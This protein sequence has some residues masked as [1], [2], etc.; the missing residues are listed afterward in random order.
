MLLVVSASLLLAVEA[1]PLA[2]PN[3]NLGLSDAAPASFPC[4]AEVTGT[5]IYLRSGPGMNFYRCGKLSIPEKLT[6]VEQKDGWSKVTPPAGSFSWISKEYV[7][8]DSEHPETGLI[9]A[10]DTRVWAGSEYVEPMHSTSLQVKLSKGAKV[11]LLGEEKGDYYK[12]APPAGASLDQH[13]VHSRSRRRL[14]QPRNDIIR[15][16]QC[17]SGYERC[18]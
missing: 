13:P 17:G 3:S 6:V 18:H 16:R 15:R 5:D 2:E 11:N 10:D 9:T 12:I 7:K 8:F 14:A 1:A 4:V